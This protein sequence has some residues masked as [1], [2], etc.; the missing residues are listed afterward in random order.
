MDSARSLTGARYGAITT[1]DD[2]GRLLDF[3]TSGLSAEERERMLALREGPQLFEYFRSIQ[4]PV[5]FQDVADH[6]RSLGFPDGHPPVK[7]LL[8]TPMRHQGAEY[9]AWLRSARRGPA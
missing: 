9:A 6:T 2:S 7:A 8:G 5:R 3:I 1:L 4:G